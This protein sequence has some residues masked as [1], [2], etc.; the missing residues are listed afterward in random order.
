MLSYQHAFHAGNHADVLKHV[1]LIA[2]LRYLTAKPKDLWYID[3]HAGAGMYELGKSEVAAREAGTGIQRLWNAT[4]APPMVLTYLEQLA[5]L[6]PSGKLELYPG[7][8]WIAADILRAHDRL[9]FSELHPAEHASLLN[10]FG[11]RD[12]RT[13][14]ER[15]DGLLWLKALLPPTPKRALVMIDPS[16]DVTSDY[17][18]VAA[19]LA[20]ARRRFATG[21]YAIWYPL[22]RLRA[23]REFPQALEAAAGPKWLHA[24]LVVRDAAHGGLFGSGL[25]VVNPPFTLAESFEPTLS[26]LA[27]RLAQDAHGTYSIDSR[28]A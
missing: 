16:Y 25:F 17:R 13:R 28:S 18:N 4:D 20:D 7:S 8:P 15:R 10:T 1:A 21:V 27:G 6:N 19:A 24:R 12:R 14:I 2:L 3:T 23:A 22:L 5:R 26:W 9:W 11:D